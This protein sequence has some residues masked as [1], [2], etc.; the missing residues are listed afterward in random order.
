MY[1]HF[2]VCVA[3]GTRSRMTQLYAFVIAHFVFL[4]VVFVL[5]DGLAADV[6]AGVGRVPPVPLGVSHLSAEAAILSGDLG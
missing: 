6:P 5:G 3:R 4:L 2:D 1:I